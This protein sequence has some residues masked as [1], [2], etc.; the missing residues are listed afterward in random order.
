MSKQ[1]TFMNAQAP[2]L[3]QTQ[4]HFYEVWIAVW[5]YLITYFLPWVGASHR[6]I[7]IFKNYTKSNPTHFKNIFF[8][9]A[10]RATFA[11]YSQAHVS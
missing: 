3:H 6:L 4:S 1:V 11:L 5:S 9:L 8:S 7:C 2:L 10:Q